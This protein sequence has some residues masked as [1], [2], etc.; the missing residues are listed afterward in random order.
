MIRHDRT[1]WNMMRH[2][3]QD[4]WQQI[5]NQPLKSCLYKMSTCRSSSDSASGWMCWGLKARANM[6]KQSIGFT[7]L[8]HC[9]L[10]IGS[11]CIHHNKVAELVLMIGSMTRYRDLPKQVKTRPCCKQHQP[12]LQS[13]LSWAASMLCLQGWSRAENWLVQS[14]CE[15]FFSTNSS[16]SQPVYD[17]PG[18]FIKSTTPYPQN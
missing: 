2:R 1:W 13:V 8:L 10:K 6:D 7:G 11:A 4:F 14:G 9:R 16:S 15:R 17:Q 18:P 12:K 3:K 5:F